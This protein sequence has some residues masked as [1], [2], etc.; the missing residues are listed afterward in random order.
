ML[1]VLAILTLSLS[2]FF[3][4]T[5]IAFLSA[6][7][8]K[9][10]LKTVQGNRAAAILSNFTKKTSEVLITILIGNNFALV[11]F[12]IMMEALL[13]PSIATYLGLTEENAYLL[14]TLTQ[15]LCATL[16]VLVFAEYIPKAIFRSNA[17]RV[18]YPAAYPLNA[19]YYLFYAPVGIVNSVSKF[20]LRYVFR[21]PMEERVVELGKQDLDHFIQEAIAGGE[22][23][24]DFVLDTEMLNNALAL[25]E[26]K[27]RECM[28]PRMDIIAAPETVEISE[29]IDQFVETNLSKIIIYG[30]SLDQV[31][32]FVHSSSMFS[33][34]E[35]IDTLIQPVLIVPETMPANVLIAEL[36]G[37]QRSMAVVVDEFGGTSGIIT[38]EDLVEE[39]FGEIEDEHDPEEEE[40]EEDMVQIQLEENIYQLGARLAIDD[41]NEELEL[42]LPEEEYYTTL[43][44]LIMY[45]AERIPQEEEVVTINKYQITILRGTANRLIQVKLQTLPEV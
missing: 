16:I 27:A 42:N 20:L 38:L 13:A 36:I 24:P 25:R 11:I 9:I 41:L 19:F 35:A 1:V 32:G 39:V 14:Y 31:L 18:I 2:F 26:T 8:L 33:K 10:E 3:S 29:L 23:T 22:E 7:R 12:T 28:I 17:D 40:V 6:N 44:G 37:N 45:I 43:G 5:E 21:L 15:S 30:E 4:G 34:P